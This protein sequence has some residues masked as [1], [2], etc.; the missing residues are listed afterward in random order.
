MGLYFNNILSVVRIYN[1]KSH[2]LV[3][4]LFVSISSGFFEKQDV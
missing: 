1:L 2:L 4:G 3:S